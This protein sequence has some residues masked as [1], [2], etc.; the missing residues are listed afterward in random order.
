MTKDDIFEKLQTE[1]TIRGMS[2]STYNIILHSGMSSTE[3]Q[4]NSHGIP[5]IP[6]VLRGGYR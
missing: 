1:I 3:R 4:V 6:R 5:G 2:P